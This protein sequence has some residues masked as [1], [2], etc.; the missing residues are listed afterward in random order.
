MYTYGVIF[1]ITIKAIIIIITLM[2]L[3]FRGGCLWVA[4]AEASGKMYEDP[5][6]L[7]GLSHQWKG[8]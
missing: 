5:F 7:L 4:V 8:L 1:L 3:T 2:A 6:S